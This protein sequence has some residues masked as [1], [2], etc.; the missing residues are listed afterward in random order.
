M[1]SI[2]LYLIALCVVFGLFVLLCNVYITY[3][4]LTNQYREMNNVEN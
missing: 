4:R 1:L 3:D 2:Y